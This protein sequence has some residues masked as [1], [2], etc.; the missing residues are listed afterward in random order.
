M[1]NITKS[2]GKR[3]TI[4]LTE[5]AAEEL[6]RI[7]T[8]AGTSLPDLFRHS[9]SLLRIYVDAKQTGKELAIIDKSG[10]QI[11]QL[12]LPLPNHIGKD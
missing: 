7:A 9:I 1:E 6:N 12:V 10:E 2:R 11:R 4:E 5:S 3:V 8:L